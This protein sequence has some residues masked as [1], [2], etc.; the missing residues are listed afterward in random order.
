MFDD[1]IKL[2]AVELK[3]I[4]REVDLQTLVMSLQGVPKEF[5]EHILTHVSQG[6]AEIIRE[7]LELNK[8]VPGRATRDAQRK[9]ALIARRLEKEGQIRIPEV[10][11]DITSARYGSL[12]D[13]LKLPSGMKLE[14][15]AAPADN[16]P[17]GENKTDENIEER[18]RRFMARGAYDKERFPNDQSPPAEGKE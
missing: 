11:D 10:H 4:L 3:T 14:E 17:P 13:V 12:R 16:A 18:I 2:D 5:M 6:K 8:I 9:I 7:E 1:L 15:A